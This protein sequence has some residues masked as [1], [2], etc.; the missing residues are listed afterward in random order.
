MLDLF[1]DADVLTASGDTV[2][3][4]FMSDGRA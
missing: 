1:L 4:A 3:C 2:V